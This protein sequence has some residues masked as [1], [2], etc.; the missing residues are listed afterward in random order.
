MILLYQKA[1]IYENVVTFIGFS[2]SFKIL[3]LMLRR[4]LV[5]Q[6]ILRYINVNRETCIGL[7]ISFKMYKR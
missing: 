5:Y 4:L 7:S 3:A 2:I 6:L 1:L